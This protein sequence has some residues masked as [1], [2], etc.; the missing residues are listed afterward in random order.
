MKV[1]CAEGAVLCLKRSSNCLPNWVTFCHLSM[2]FACEIGCTIAPR[3]AEDGFDVAVNDVSGT[4]GL[5]GLVKEIEGK[6]RRSLG[7]PAGVSLEP[8]VEKMM[9]ANA[10]IITIESFLN[11]TVESFDRLMAVNARGTTLCYKHAG[12]QM[13]AQGRC[14]RITAGRSSNTNAAPGIILA[15]SATKFAACSLTQAAARE[16]GKYRIAANA[17]SPGLMGTSMSQ[18]LLF[19]PVRR[20]GTPEDTAGLVS[21]FASDGASFITGAQISEARNH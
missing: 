8:E 3:L 18:F 17:Y 2:G 16:F 12:R 9:V 14:G 21:C 7:V 19:A 11:V 10:G 1:P 20:L 13:I 6:G 5:D 4:L 15:Y